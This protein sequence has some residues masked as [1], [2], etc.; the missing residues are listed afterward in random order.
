MDLAKL[1]VELRHAANT[2]FADIDAMKRA[3]PAIEYLEAHATLLQ[4]QLTD[5][6]A[7]KKEWQQRASDLEAKIA[8]LEKLRAAKRPTDEKIL[9]LAAEH[10]LPVRFP[11]EIL[12]F[13]RNLLQG[14]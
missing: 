5:E 8:E 3:L 13:A 1:K 4:K 6:H 12:A 7:S 14:R 2:G 9:N 10:H 11:H